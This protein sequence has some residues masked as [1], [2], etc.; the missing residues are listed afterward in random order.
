[1]SIINSDSQGDFP[2]IFNFSAP[3][4]GNASTGSSE[5]KIQRLKEEIERLRADAG[6]KAEK[7]GNARSTAEELQARSSYDFGKAALMAANP[8]NGGLGMLAAGDANN[9]KQQAFNLKKEAGELDRASQQI[10]QQ[11]PGKEQ[12][13]DKLEEE[14]VKKKT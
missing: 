12:E 10:A 14:K 5:G 13:L 1:M 6:D 3:G 9:L 7:A 8:F 4:G 2:R 11:I